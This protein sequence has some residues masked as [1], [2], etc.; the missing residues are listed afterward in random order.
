MFPCGRLNFQVRIQLT[1]GISRLGLLEIQATEKQVSNELI[2][3]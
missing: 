2:W 3:Q 1:P